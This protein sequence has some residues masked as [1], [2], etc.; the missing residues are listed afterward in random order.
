MPFLYARMVSNPQLVTFYFLILTTISVDGVATADP[1]FGKVGILID[2]GTVII[3]L[4]LPIYKAV[5][6]EFLKQF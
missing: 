2:S 1:C 3:R 5:K 4:P 6:N